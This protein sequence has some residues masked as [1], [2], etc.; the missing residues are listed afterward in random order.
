GLEF[1]GRVLQQAEV[2]GEQAGQG[3]GGREL[4]TDGQW[5]H[6]DH[7][8][9]WMRTRWPAGNSGSAS[10]ATS[11]RAARTAAMDSG[12]DTGRHP[13]GGTSPVTANSQAP[14][15]TPKEMVSARATSSSG[16]STAGRSAR[17][18]TSSGHGSRAS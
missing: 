6:F 16:V 5:G 8:T 4:G 7:L 14:S 1:G 2:A 3:T 13:S 18:S 10:P 12:N 9:G 17:T 11:S 15:L